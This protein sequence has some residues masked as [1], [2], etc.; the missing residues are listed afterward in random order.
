MELFTTP[1]A[2]LTKLIEFISNVQAQAT[3]LR[4]IRVIIAMLNSKICIYSRWYFCI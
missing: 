4:G 1:E 2:A 3:R